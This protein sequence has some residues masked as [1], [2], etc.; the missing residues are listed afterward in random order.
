M[1]AIRWLN[2][3]GVQFW[4][5]SQTVRQQWLTVGVKSDRGATVAGSHDCVVP[6]YDVGCP[7][8]IDSCGQAVVDKAVLHE[9]GGHARLQGRRFMA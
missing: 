7:F 4:Y 2:L 8:D 1:H 3:L 6:D 5:A 9:Y